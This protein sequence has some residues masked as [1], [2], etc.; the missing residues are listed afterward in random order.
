VTCLRALDAVALGDIRTIGAV[1]PTVTPQ[2]PAGSP[3][4]GRWPPA[5]AAPAEAL[6]LRPRT[7]AGIQAVDADE[8]SGDDPDEGHRRED[9]HLAAGRGRLR[10]LLLGVLLLG[11]LLL[12]VVCWSGGRLRDTRR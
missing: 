5:R 12:G 4:L 11:V 1:A 3:P 7:C 9:D 10:V 8:H 6:R 2:S